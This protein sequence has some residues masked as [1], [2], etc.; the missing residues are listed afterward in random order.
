MTRNPRFQKATETPLFPWSWTAAGKDERANNT[1]CFPKKKKNE[2]TRVRNAELVYVDRS[3]GGYGSFWCN[4]RQ[5]RIGLL[6]V[7]HVV[8]KFTKEKKIKKGGVRNYAQWQSDWRR[9]E[10]YGTG[11]IGG[12]NGAKQKSRKLR[13]SQQEQQQGRA[14]RASE[15]GDC[16]SSEAR[17]IGLVERKRSGSKR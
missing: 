17:S 12:G 14:E 11:R 3:L 13:E 8:C 5:R 16:C 10:R 2:H 4:R 6:P 15:N 1:F 7:R 9:R